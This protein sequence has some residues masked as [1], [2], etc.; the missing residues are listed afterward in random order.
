MLHAGLCWFVSADVKNA[1]SPFP[2][3]T[4]TPGYPQP[5]RAPTGVSPR[6]TLEG[7]TLDP[8]PSPLCRLACVPGWIRVEQ[9]EAFG[10]LVLIYCEAADKPAIRN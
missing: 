4:P 5:P 2:E 7:H 1:S 8:R 9:P 6:R 3:N 10:C